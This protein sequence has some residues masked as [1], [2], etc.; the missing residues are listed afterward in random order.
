WHAEQP[1]GA[2]AS[3]DGQQLIVVGIGHGAHVLT[4]RRQARGKSHCA[5]VMDS[6]GFFEA[7]RRQM[8][9]F[10]AEA[11]GGDRG[12][13]CGERVQL[14]TG[15]GVPENDP[16]VVAGGGE[17][18]AVGRVVDGS[19]PVGVAGELVHEL[20][21]GEAPNADVMVVAGGGQP[22]SAAMNADGGDYRRL[23]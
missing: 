14:L 10:M 23:V 6:D 11:N 16:S 8:L 12:L 9:T 13:V 22:L 5:D 17:D 19:D 7:N 15:Q 20:A 2:A 1:D 18:A 4:G 3:A 21:V